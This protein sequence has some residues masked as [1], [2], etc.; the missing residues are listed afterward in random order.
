MVESTVA[1][2]C[3]LTDTGSPISQERVW[4][5]LGFWPGRS[6]F[7]VPGSEKAQLFWQGW[8]EVCEEAARKLTEVFQAQFLTGLE[9]IEE[10]LY[11]TALEDPDTLRNRLPSAW[12]KMFACLR[13]LTEIPIQAIQFA[14]ALSKH[15][16]GGMKLVPEGVYRQRLSVCATCEFFRDNHCLQCGCR[17]GGDV[18]AKARWASEQCPL[19]KWQIPTETPTR[20]I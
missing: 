9:A 1:E 14:E 18:L 12:Q 7:W 2:V 19:G 20:E 13:P 10:G 17:M 6:P 5:W 16:G 4:P 15:V 3:R 11:L 8:T